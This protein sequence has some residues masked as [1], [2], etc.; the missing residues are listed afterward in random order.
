MVIALGEGEVFEGYS[1]NNIRARARENKVD[2]IVRKR[3]KQSEKDN[4]D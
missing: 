1:L 3:T 4:E 2:D